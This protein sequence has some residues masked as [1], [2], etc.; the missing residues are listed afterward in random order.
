MLNEK[1]RKRNRKKHKEADD[2]TKSQRQ[3]DKVQD[4]CGQDPDSLRC[5]ARVRPLS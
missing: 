5:K 4:H 2:K 3:R 1:F